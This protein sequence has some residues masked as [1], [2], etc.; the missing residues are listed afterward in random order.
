MDEDI[1]LQKE[2]ERI[3]KRRV[4]W[5]AGGGIGVE[6]PGPDVGD[7]DAGAPIPDFL[8]PNQQGGIRNYLDVYLYIE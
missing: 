4:V 8:D 5:S 6:A 2:H 3:V 1:L 7:D